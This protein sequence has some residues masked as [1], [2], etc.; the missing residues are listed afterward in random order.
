MSELATINFEERLALHT[1]LKTLEDA[2]YRFVNV[3][4]HAA[5][6]DLMHQ[7]GDCVKNAKLV[8][9]SQSDAKVQS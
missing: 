9:A 8:L 3:A 4:D 5:P 7:F 6:V 1:R 2:L